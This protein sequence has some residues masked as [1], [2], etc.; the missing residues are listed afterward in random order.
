MIQ[1]QIE[2]RLHDR[3]NQAGI[4]LL[5]GPRGCGKSWLASQLGSTAN[6][7]LLL[8][9]E[10]ADPGTFMGISTPDQ[11]RHRFGG[12]DLLI[13]DEAQRFHGIKPAV[14]LLSAALP[15]LKVLLLSSFL[16]PGIER[17]GHADSTF[18]L[19]PLSTTELYDQGGITAVSEELPRRLVQGNYPE[20]YLAGDDFEDVLE[21]L[22]RQSLRM[23][24]AQARDI[25]RP[26]QL[27]RLLGVLAG[28]LGRQISFSELAREA[29]MDAKTAERYL[30]LLERAYLVYR[31][32]SYS[33]SVRN[34]LKRSFK[35]CFWDNGIRNLA[36][37]DFR[38]IG[39]RQDADLLWQNYFITERRKAAL[40]AGKG[41]R[42]HFWRSTQKQEVALVELTGRRVSAYSVSWAS[43]KY[44]RLPLT[45]RNGYPGARLE[46]ASRSDYLFHTLEPQQV[47]PL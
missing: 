40:Y 35:V 45:F 13:I 30:G 7:V 24:I 25:R 39:R 28:R 43:D 42:Q 3:L 12:Y 47:L 9:G 32:S 46:T 15:T 22:C 11:A 23:D 6:R 1:R 44:G 38:P 21:S 16:T 2:G 14:A 17:L 4:V 34:E 27:M 31:L 33:G 19:G 20:A 18:F 10:R 5:C 29:G 26:E 37:G 8:D 41:V 36:C